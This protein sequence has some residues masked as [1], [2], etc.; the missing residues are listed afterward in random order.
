MELQ[1]SGS[2]LLNVY[3][4]ATILS[5]PFSS[6]HQCLSPMPPSVFCEGDSLW[7]QQSCRLFRAIV[8]SKC[9]FWDMEKPGISWSLIS[10]LSLHWSP[11][12]LRDLRALDTER[13]TSALERSISMTCFAGEEIFC[14]Y[15]KIWSK[16][17]WSWI[18]TFYS[19]FLNACS[20]TNHPVTNCIKNKTLQ[21]E[22]LKC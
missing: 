12:L 18:S 17:N 8:L 9:D 3:L 11:A 4:W 14:L 10:V 1:P 7:L 13:L 21:I 6:L 20:M 2:D 15:I 22:N 16:I 5:F 19:V